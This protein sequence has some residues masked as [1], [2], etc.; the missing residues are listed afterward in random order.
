MEVLD[1]VPTAAASAV[2]VRRRLVRIHFDEIRASAA[3]FGLDQVA[4]CK[5]T[6]PNYAMVTILLYMHIA[7][8]MKKNE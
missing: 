8:A 7:I 3:V 2:D 5:L 6:Q 4:I 1:E